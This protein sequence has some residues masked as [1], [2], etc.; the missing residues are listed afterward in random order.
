MKLMD[1]RLFTICWYICLCDD[2]HVYMCVC[3]C[4]SVCVCVYL[5]ARVCVCVRMYV[6]TTCVHKYVQYGVHLSNCVYVRTYMC[7]LCVY[8]I[9]VSHMCSLIGTLHYL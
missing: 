2:K 7:T 3:V 1:L 9:S 4:I 8:Y 5:Y 6:G